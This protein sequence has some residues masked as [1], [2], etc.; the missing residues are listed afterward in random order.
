MGGPVSGPE[1]LM[2]PSSADI[3]PVVFWTIQSRIGR[4]SV[5]EATT[6]QSSARKLSSAC[7]IC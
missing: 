7:R 1:S 5:F 3:M 2:D 6:R 4:I